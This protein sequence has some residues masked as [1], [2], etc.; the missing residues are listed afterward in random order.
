MLID[1][2]EPPYKVAGAV[3]LVILAAVFVLISLQSRGVFRPRTDL[4][5][6]SPRS[7]LV[8]DPG[9]KVTLNGVEI[10]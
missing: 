1:R 2:H 7:G 3:L 4:T 5:V 6:V 10:G 9:S 8:V